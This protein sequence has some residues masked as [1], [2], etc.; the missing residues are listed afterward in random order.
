LDEEGS[1]RRAGA[2]QEDDPISLRLESK[3][4]S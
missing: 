1:E 3:D 2:P 4:A